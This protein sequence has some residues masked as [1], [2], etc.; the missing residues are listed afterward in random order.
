MSDH[1]ENH[2]HN[3]CDGYEALIAVP[4]VPVLRELDD[5]KVDPEVN[6]K[7]TE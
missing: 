5:D 4:L 1:A 6:N 7:N 2:G 3:S